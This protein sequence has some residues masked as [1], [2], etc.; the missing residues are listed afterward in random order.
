MKSSVVGKNI[1]K[2]EVVHVSPHGI[3]LLVNEKEYFL[4]YQ[5]F[6]W[7]KDASI[8]QILDV[9]LLHQ[10]HL[11]WPSL[12]VDLRLDTIERIEEYPLIYE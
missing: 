5:D 4:P 12:D 11:F 8:T 2:A 6:P 1:S 7:F 9:K 3:W 10:G